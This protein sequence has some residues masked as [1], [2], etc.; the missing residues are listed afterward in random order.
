[1]P[2]EARAPVNGA[3]PREIGVALENAVEV[4][5]GALPGVVVYRNPIVAVTTRS[6]RPMQSGIGGAG[7]PDLHV[8][9]RGPDGHFRCVWMECKAGSGRLS[10]D[11]RKWHARA[12]VLGR[13]VYVVRSVGHAVAIVESFRRGEIFD[14]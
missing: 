8:E 6:G 14:V 1:M 10:P 12:A 9:V 2:R 3:A 11:Q 13:H 4:A 7:A 5:I